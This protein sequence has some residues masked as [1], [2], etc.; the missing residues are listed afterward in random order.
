MKAEKGWRVA[1]AIA[2]W[3]VI[4]RFAVGAVKLRGTEMGHAEIEGIR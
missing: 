1:G 3:E 4:E 2:L